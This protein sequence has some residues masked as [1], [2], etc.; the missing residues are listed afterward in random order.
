MSAEAERRYTNETAQILGM[1]NA[2]M[3]VYGIL[4]RL[5]A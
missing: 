4:H 1:G 3:S 5:Q 2:G